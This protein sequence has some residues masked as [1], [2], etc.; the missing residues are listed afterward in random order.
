MITEIN[1]VIDKS[2]SK[3]KVVRLNHN[4]SL[5]V[6]FTYKVED[7]L[8]DIIRKYIKGYIGGDYL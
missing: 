8:I 7:E 3:R 1:I 2:D 4:G 5:G 6:E